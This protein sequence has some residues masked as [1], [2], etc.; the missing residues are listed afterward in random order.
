MALM[1]ALFS[2]T[3]MLLFIT[4]YLQLVI[5]LDPLKAGLWT[6]PGAA[7]NIVLCIAAPVAVRAYTTPAPYCRRVGAAG[8][9][10]IVP[11]HDNRCQ[12]PAHADYSH[13]IDVRMRSCRNT[14]D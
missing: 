10:H 2:W 9:R 11:Y 12:W 4:Q 7:A 13:R 14:I 5:G 6:M 8:M 1:I 3:G